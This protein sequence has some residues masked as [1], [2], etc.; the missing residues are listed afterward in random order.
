MKI[1]LL[2]ISGVTLLTTAGCIF[3]GDRRGGDYRGQGEYRSHEDY[4]EHSEHRDPEPG[5]SV[6][7]HAD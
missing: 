7:I 1:I 6:R 4:R 3:P 2:L 5:V